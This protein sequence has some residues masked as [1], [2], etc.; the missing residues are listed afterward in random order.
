MISL[1]LFQKGDFIGRDAL[2]KQKDHGIHQKFVQFLLDDFDVHA[3]LWPWGGEP[4]Y[5]NGEF[6]GQITT[7]SYGFTLDQMVCLGYVSDFDQQGKPQ[8]KKF[9]N[10]WVMEKDAHYEVDIAGRKYSAK[11]GIYTPKLAMSSFEASFIPVPVQ[12]HK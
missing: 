6:V 10:K 5:R 4:V 9:M 2:Q 8:V 11:A 3:D 7:C 1:L 12:P